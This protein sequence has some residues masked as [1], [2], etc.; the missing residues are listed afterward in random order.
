MMVVRG[1]ISAAFFGAV[2]GVILPW[3]IMTYMPGPSTEIGDWRWAGLALLVAGGVVCL[4]C[5]AQLITAG[6]GTSAPFY[7]TKKLVATGLYRYS[8]NP[9]YV[10]GVLL[11]IGEAVIGAS[12]LLLAYALALG[13]AAHLFVVYYEEPSL[14]RRFGAEYHDYL[15][16]SPR[17]FSWRRG[18]EEHPN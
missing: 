3:V 11:L 4:W 18:A 6:Q 17:W 2:V 16:R 9:M 8:R 1:I 13:V 10:G 5:V 15:K 12:P 14:I 7:P